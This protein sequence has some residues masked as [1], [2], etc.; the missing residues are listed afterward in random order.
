MKLE[1]AIERVRDSGESQAIEIL[2]KLKKVVLYYN[3]GSLFYVKVETMAGESITG[4]KALEKIMCFRDNYSDIKIRKVGSKEL[5]KITASRETFEKK[6]P[7]YD[8]LKAFFFYITPEEVALLLSLAYKN[9]YFVVLDT[10]WKDAIFDLWENGIVEFN[11]FLIYMPEAMRFLIKKLLL[12][13]LKK[14]L[15]RRKNKKEVD[16]LKK[17]RISQPLA[18][19]LKR[20]GF[21]LLDKNLPKDLIEGLRDFDIPEI[22]K[23]KLLEKYS[24][25]KPDVEDIKKLLE[26]E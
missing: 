1:D 9:R 23:E 22:N 18:E 11:G 7:G 15:K 14:G 6:L 26:E 16:D 3:D 4:R 21:L 8:Q 20:E 13:H 25:A 24:I 17:G 10:G 12:E 5:F 19:F 2:Y